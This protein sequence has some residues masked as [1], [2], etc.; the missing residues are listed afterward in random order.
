MLHGFGFKR[1]H[2]VSAF[3]LFAASFLLSMTQE[4]PAILA[5]C[6]ATGAVF[7]LRLRG[8]K[9]VS[10]IARFILPVFVLIT[11]FNALINHYG[12]TVLFFM[13]NGA[14][15][16][17]E[18]AVYGSVFASK[19]VSALLW[20][21]CLNEILTAEK[22]V[23]LFGRI[24]PKTA[25]VVSMAL[26]FIPLLR[27]QSKQISDALKGAG[28]SGSSFFEKLRLAARK[29]SVLVSWT[30][31]RGIDTADSMAARG[32]GSGKRTFY[33]G[34]KFGAADAAF[35]AGAV[36]VCLLCFLQREALFAIYNPFIKVAPIS[37]ASVMAAAVTAAVLFAPSV[38]DFAEEKRWSI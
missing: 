12:V 16:T 29:L 18:A 21:D 1:I 26:R 36:T 19:T 2:P 22:I 24:S 14:A 13:K 38:F 30:L 15:V 17:L 20:L 25:I 33:N 28:K 6:V 32:Y 35:A 10:F 5:I 11:V 34:Y 7:D 37:A 8:K 23:Y 27:S 9:A 3:L 4:H 31:E